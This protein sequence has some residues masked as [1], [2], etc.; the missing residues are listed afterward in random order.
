MTN[1][2]NEEGFTLVETVIAVA[3]LAIGIIG[4]YSM[5]VT[6]IKGNATANVITESTNTVRDRIEQ[7][8]C[9]DFNDSVFDEGDHN[10]TGV[11][12]INSIQ[13][14]VT[15][16]QSDGIDND[17]DGRTDEFDERGV[18]SI[19]LTVQYMVRG[20]VKNNAVTFL[21]TEIF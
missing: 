5:N 6:G 8:L 16:W 14:T 18:K 10:E 7:F 13:W 15:D 1:I 9:D 20:V 19:Q 4:L 11:S 17:I 3:V 21:K 12:P 2:Q